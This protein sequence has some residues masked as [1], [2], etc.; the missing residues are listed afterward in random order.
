MEF[1]KLVFN[2]S[3]KDL[4]KFLDMV[5]LFL[6]DPTSPKKS[7]II[8]FYEELIIVYE[9]GTTERA[10]LDNLMLLVN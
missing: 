9:V 2:M 4:D 10:T 8:L 6:K 3:K 1:G 5:V 7:D